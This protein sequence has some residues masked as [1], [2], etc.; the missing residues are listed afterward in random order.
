MR[1]IKQSGKLALH[2]ETLR[3]LGAEELTAV[4]GGSRACVEES[5]F[6]PCTNKPP[7]VTGDSEGPKSCKP[8]DCMPRD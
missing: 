4:A 3:R 1:S 5:V 2:R 7:T 8:A 6:R